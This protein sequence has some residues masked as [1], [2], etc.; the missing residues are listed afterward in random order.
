MFTLDPMVVSVL[1]AL[2]T[3]AALVTRAWLGL[4][5]TEIRER[6][7][8]ERLRRALEDTLPKQ[9]PDILR[10]MHESGTPPEKD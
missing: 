6:A 2:S 9:R 3:S 1:L 10:A 4:R 7:R 5:K 8:T